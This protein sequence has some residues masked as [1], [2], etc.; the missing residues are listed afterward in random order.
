MDD[1]YFFDS[2]AVIE[3]I[4][5]NPKFD[6]FKSSNAILTKLNLFEVDYFLRR[7]GTEA[8]TEEEIFDKYS[9]HVVDFRLETIRDA[10]DLK[11]NNKSLSM[12]DCIG[13][14]VAQEYGI[15]FLTGDKEFEGMPGVEFVK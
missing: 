1:L 6:R 15:K 9:N 13:Y 3:L 8:A 2:Y 10:T 7:V 12:T 11:I 5:G 14:R 4:K